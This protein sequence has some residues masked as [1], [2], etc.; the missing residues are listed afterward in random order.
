MKRSND[1]YKL[2]VVKIIL[3]AFLWSLLG[4]LMI[5]LSGKASVFSIC[6]FRGI[7]I[8][9]ISFLN[10]KKNIND[11]HR[12]VLSKSILGGAAYAL[13]AITYIYSLNYLSVSVAAPLHYTS[14]IFILL[15]MFMLINKLPSIN[16]LIGTIFGL[17]GSLILALEAQSKN[18][19]FLGVISALLSAASWGYYLYLSG[20]LPENSRTFA[21]AIGGI[22]LAIFCL[23]FSSI[24]ILDTRSIVILLLMG[25]LSSALPLIILSSIANLVSTVTTSLL[26][27]SEPVFA[28]VLAAFLGQIPSF[29]AVLSSA[30]IILGAGVGCCKKDLLDFFKKES[31]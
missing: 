3:A 27:L 26:L 5:L 6:L 9:F 16:E 20:K 18:L 22:F 17:I 11:L 14:P 7:F 19:N 4:P 31:V 2:A 23:P 29:L 15:G 8:T 1:I 25:I 24:T 10:L 12:L 13:S 28:I 30:L 21:V